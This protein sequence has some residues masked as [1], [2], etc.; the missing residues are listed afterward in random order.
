MPLLESLQLAALALLIAALLVYLYRVFLTT[1]WIGLRCQAQLRV[2]S[3]IIVV[4][5]MVAL[6]YSVLQPFIAM[7]IAAGRGI[8]TL[9]VLLIVA[10]LLILMFQN[11]GRRSSRL[12]ASSTSSRTI[13]KC[14][15]TDRPFAHSSRRR[16]WPTAVT[17]PLASCARAWNGCSNP[18]S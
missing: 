6:L 4:L 11:F 14:P 5:L 18:R 7:P 3:E 12:R 9:I 2:A 16:S 10:V 8:G 13:L 15:T 1:P 17:A